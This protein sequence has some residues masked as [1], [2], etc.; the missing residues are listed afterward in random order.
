MHSTRTGTAQ[1]ACSSQSAQAKAECGVLIG[2][3]KGGVR[4]VISKGSGRKGV[5]IKVVRR[6]GGN[7]GG[8]SI[9]G[10][11]SSNYRW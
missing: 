11:N 10:D 7:K 1:H 9:K 6:G 8:C 5:E 2:G 3:G 4:R